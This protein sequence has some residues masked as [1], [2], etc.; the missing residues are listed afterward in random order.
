MAAD[1][2][3]ASRGVVAVQNSVAEVGARHDVHSVH[4]FEPIGEIAGKVAPVHAQVDGEILGCGVELMQ[5]VLPL[6]EVVANFLVRHRDGAAAAAVGE[7]VL[8]GG[9]Q[10]R[11]GDLIAPM[12]V[13]HRPGQRGMGVDDV[14][15]LRGVD[16]DVQ[17]AVHGHLAQLGEQAGVVLRR[18][19]RGVDAE[20]LGDPQQHRHGQRADVVLDLVQVAR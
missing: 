19:E 6:V 2:E 17:V 14:G 1:L 4:R 10:L 5:V 8:G 20:H 7:P 15:D 3:P 12:Q 13:D 9:G 11:C 18:E 16:V